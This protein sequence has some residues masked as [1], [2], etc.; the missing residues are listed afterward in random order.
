[1]TIV[2]DNDARIRLKHATRDRLR[3]MKRGGESYDDVI[4][5]LADAYDGDG[6]TTVTST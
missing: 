4:N 2:P 3:S 6:D 1:M 5:R